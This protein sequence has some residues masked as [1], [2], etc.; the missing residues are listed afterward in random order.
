VDWR[1][2]SVTS[3]WRGL[4]TDGSEQRPEAWPLVRSSSSLSINEMKRW[5]GAK[6][7]KH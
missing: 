4:M 5:L 1:S 3:F 2:M 6:Q 7:A